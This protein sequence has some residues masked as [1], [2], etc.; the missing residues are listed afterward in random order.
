MTS[1]A[2]DMSESEFV[3]LFIFNIL[4]RP[5]ST[6]VQQQQPASFY[7]VQIYAEHFTGGY[8]FYRLQVGDRMEYRRTLHLK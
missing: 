7:P 5:I 1:L 2:G 6:L 8:Y 3:F 4:R